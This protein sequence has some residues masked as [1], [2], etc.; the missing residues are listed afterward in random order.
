MKQRSE[1]WRDSNPEK[2]AAQRA[3]TNA[4]SRGIS[5]DLSY[6]DIEIPEV[7]PVFG[8]PFQRKTDYAA[9]VDRIDNTKGYTRDNIQVISR[10][11]NLMKNSASK[12][13]LIAFAKWVLKTYD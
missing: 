12:E 5:F 2:W 9:S 10:L 11:A 13:Q 7:C 3:R 4:K 6:K 8:V 1:H